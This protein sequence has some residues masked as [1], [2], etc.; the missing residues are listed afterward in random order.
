MLVK[1]AVQARRGPVPD[2]MMDQRLVRPVPTVFIGV[3]GGFMVGLTSVGSGSLM[4]VMLMLLYPTLSSRE[5]VGTD[6]VQAIPLVGAAAIGH[7]LFGNLALG[8]TLSVLVGAMPG[9]YLGAQVSSRA[10]DRY[11]RPV[12]VAVLA[13]SALKLLDVPNS[14]LLGASGIALVVLA[15]VFIASNRRA[16]VRARKDAALTP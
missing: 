3:V 8:L 4:I 10:S 16:A 12:L 5:M 11:I 14:T 9:V 6:L 1:I 7:L 13:I 2:V 15:G